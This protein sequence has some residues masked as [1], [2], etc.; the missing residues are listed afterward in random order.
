M[1]TSEFKEHSIFEKLGL[2]E[3]TIAKKENADKIDL[4][5]LDFFKASCSYMRTQLDKA[6]TSLINSA[7]LTA[8][9]S[10]I[11]AA[12]GQINT[13]IGNDN[14][15]HLTNAS[16]NLFNS[17]SKARNFPTPNHEGGFSYS[18]VIND[19]KSLVDQKIDSLANSIVEK[20]EELESLRTELDEKEKELEKISKT[21]IEKQTIVDG[22]NTTFQTNFDQIKT[23][24]ST[25]FE[26]VRNG[27]QKQIE[28]ELKK[29]DTNTK[30]LI[31]RLDKKETEA[32]KLVNVIGNIG[33][34]GN[35]QRIA[36]AHK[37]S[38]DNWRNIAISFMTVLSIILLVTIWKIDGDT[39]NWQ[40]SLIRILSA[41][42][43]TYPATYAARES[44]KHRKL[45]NLN[46]K[47]ELELASINPFI[48]ILDEKKKQEIKEKLVEKYFGNNEGYIDKENDKSDEV[49]MTII[50]R[51]TK[52]IN[53][54]RK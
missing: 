24:E 13:F 16:N 33:A 50:E 14:V 2:L 3:S 48:E 29:I 41:L 35:Y 52:L 15:G 1:K 6:L 8:M 12:V 28:T 5:T 38:A 4:E 40:I 47:A 20:E 17:I 37:K 19:F 42:V 31:D 45:E 39:F 18:K 32:K 21:I 9:S 27:F 51:L 26:E 30:D 11:D 25:K 49:S 44:A 53:E 46:R 36:E 22:L 34:T 54:V 23:S 10:E 7:D 43:L